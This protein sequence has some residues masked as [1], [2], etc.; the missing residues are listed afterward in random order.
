[1][2]TLSYLCTRAT[3]KRVV[4]TTNYLLVHLPRSLAFC[5]ASFIF[6]NFFKKYFLI[7]TPI[8]IFS[9]LQCRKT[10]LQDKGGNKNGQKKS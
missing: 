9:M 7:M 4:A 8:V 5:Q 10:D 6:F 3:I 1:M 2:A